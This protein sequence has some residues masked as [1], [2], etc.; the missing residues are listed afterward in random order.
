MNETIDQG[1]PMRRHV[2][3]CMP[4]PRLD[5]VTARPATRNETQTVT[6]TVARTAARVYGYPV[7]F[8]QSDCPSQSGRPSQE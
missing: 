8:R 5:P 4:F 2:E 3:A 7:R 1:S 6:R